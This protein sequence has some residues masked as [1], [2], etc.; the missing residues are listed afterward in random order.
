MEG[1]RG[2]QGSHDGAKVRAAGG[3][4]KEQK[5][6]RDVQYV[7]KDVDQ[8]MSGWIHP[9]PLYIRHVRNPCERVPI[10]GIISGERPNE[11]GSSEPLQ[12]VGVIGHVV[13]VIV[14]DEPIPD[15]GRIEGERACDQQDYQN[16]FPSPVETGQQRDGWSAHLR[17][18]MLS[19]KVIEV[20]LCTAPV[21]IGTRRP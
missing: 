17:T 20:A 16:K 19:E 15:G 1:V 13:R 12:D 9:K 6:E 7:P 14:I 18:R 21:P 3:A 10:T 8:M 4:L 5:D 11:V 2:Q